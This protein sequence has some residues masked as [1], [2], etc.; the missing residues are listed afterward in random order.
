MNIRNLKP[1][2]KLMWDPQSCYPDTD[3]PILYPATVGEK[4]TDNKKLVMILTGSSRN[5]MGPEQ[6]YLRLPN[7]QELKFLIWPSYE[8]RSNKTI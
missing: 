7:E 5:W 1:G 6:G 8:N 4:H 2:T 3:I